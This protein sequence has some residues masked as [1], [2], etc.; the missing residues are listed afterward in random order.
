MSVYCFATLHWQIVQ[1]D[2][3]QDTLQSLLQWNLQIK[4][5]LGPGFCH[6]KRG[7]PSYK[8]IVGTGN[9]KPVVRKI[10]THAHVSVWICTHAFKFF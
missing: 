8:C 1:G 6:F 5:A 2:R 7:C 9:F 4:D 3:Y 10:S